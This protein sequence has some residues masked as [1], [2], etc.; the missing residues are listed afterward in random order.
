MEQKLKLLNK[1]KFTTSLLGKHQ[2]ENIKTALKSID[3]FLEIK[4]ITPNWE[5]I[6][7]NISKTHMIGSIPT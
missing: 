1:Y 6:T 7:K 3:V 2:L 5:L 4:S